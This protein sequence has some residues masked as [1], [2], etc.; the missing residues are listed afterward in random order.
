MTEET[1]SRFSPILNNLLIRVKETNQFITPK[2]TKYC[3]IRP[4]DDKTIKIQVIFYYSLNILDLTLKRERGGFTLKID[5][6]QSA[7]VYHHADIYLGDRLLIGEIGGKERNHV[8]R[9]I[10]IPRQPTKRKVKGKVEHKIPEPGLN[11][12]IWAPYFYE[13]SWTIVARELTRSLRKVGINAYI[14]PYTCRETNRDDPYLLPRDSC[15]ITQKDWQRYVT[16]YKIQIFIRLSHPDSFAIMNTARNT[17]PPPKLIGY[18]VV[19]SDSIN[20][21]W[22]NGCNAMDAVWGT[23]RF[24]CEVYRRCGV[25]V[26]LYH[27]PHGVRTDIFT[28]ERADPELRKRLGLE[29]KFVV[30]YVSRVDERKNLEALI[31]AYSQIETK[32]TYL[33]IH[34]D[35]LERHVKLIESLGIE[36]Y[37]YTEDIQLRETDKTGARIWGIPHEEMP[38]IYGLCLGKR[39]GVHVLPSHAE[40]F[41]LTVIEA[42]AM[43]VP[44]IAIN[45]SA[46]PEVIIDGVTGFLLPV[47][48]YEP[49]APLI[50]SGGN[51]A[52]FTP[53]SLASRIR[54]LYKDRSLCRQMGLN[55][56]NYIR[57]TFTWENAALKAKESLLEVLS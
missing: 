23:S 17:S 8:G 5:D 51:W 41:G 38:K 2:D 53:E 45:W 3:K 34:G 20:K 13:S 35:K 33:V 40:G 56:M 32:N 7:F 48:G 29:D 19:E 30:L 14:L 11:I 36:N 55:A 28:P 39:R 27:V 25:K 6:F 12:A 43:G 31:K 21:N 26:P 54:H 42:G 24:T 9:T 52:C 18:S 44:S 47:S 50:R 22:V 10:K 57:E 49:A 1:I 37:L 4:I 15:V 46:L 16:E